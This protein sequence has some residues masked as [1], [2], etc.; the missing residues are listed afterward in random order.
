MWTAR[1]TGMG[2]IRFARRVDG[3]VYE[4]ADDGAAHGY[5][6]YKRIDLNIWCRRLPDFG[7]VVCAA[8]GLVSSRPF[9]DA[10]RGDLPPEGAWVSRKDD[11]SYVYDLVRVES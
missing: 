5:P 10:G 7:W 4:F 6:S 1:M 8:S 2:G 3:L 9:D 11:Q